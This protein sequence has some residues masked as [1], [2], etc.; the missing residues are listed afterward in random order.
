[1][2]PRFWT[3]PSL[4]QPRGTTFSVSWSRFAE[5]VQ[6]ARQAPTK[7]G[8]VRWAPVHFRDSYRCRAN[9][10]ACFAVVIDVDDGS[11][12]LSTIL[13]AFSGLMVIAHTTFRATPE[14]PRWRIVLPLDQPV[15]ADPYD[16]V[17]RWLLAALEAEGGRPEY[18]GSRDSSHAWAVPARPPSG[19]YESV[20]VE[21]AFVSVAD[22]LVAIPEP[23]P[24]ALRPRH[25]QNVSYDRRVERARKYL[26]TM[27]P[28]ISGAGGHAATWRAA[29]AMV[30]GFSLDPADALAL[31]VQD[32]NPRCQP[33]WTVNELKH[34]VTQALRRGRHPFGFLVERT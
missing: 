1:M 31:L 32:Y 4:D 17:A 20:F 34:K 2:T 6:S 29:N 14:E 21:G 15:A 27:A 16:R 22:A 33:E 12:A 5:R 23:E 19:Y 8:L 28:A 25:E 7:E 26:D 13:E 9:V 11:L 10:L 18:S 30:R 24:I 3:A